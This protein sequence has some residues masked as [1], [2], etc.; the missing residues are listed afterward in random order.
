MLSIKFENIYIK[1]I[2]KYF[3]TNNNLNFYKDYKIDEEI[4]KTLI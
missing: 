1:I 2:D 4:G 3:L